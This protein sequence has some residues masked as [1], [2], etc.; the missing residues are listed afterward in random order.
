[1]MVSVNLEAETWLISESQTSVTLSLIRFKT[2][3]FR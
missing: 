3:P 2:L 1:M